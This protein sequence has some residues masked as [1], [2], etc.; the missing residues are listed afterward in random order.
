MEIWKTEKCKGKHQ[1]R[2]KLKDLK[3]ISKEKD[4]NLRI[5]KESQNNQNSQETAKMHKF[6]VGNFKN[7]KTVQICKTRSSNRK[8]LKKTQ[9]SN[10]RNQTET[11]AHRIGH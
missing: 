4:P 9:K 8:L 10:R 3:R 6:P 11:H 7:T 2:S 1:K 5:T